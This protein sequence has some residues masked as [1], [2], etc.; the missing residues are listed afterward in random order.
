MK[1]HVEET[2]IYTSANNETKFGIEITGK[3]F[4]LLTGG[5]YK[6]K[7]AAIVREISANAYD[8]HVS[9]GKEDIPFKVILPNELHPYF[10]VEDYGVGLNDEEIRTIYTVLFRST[11]QDS[12]FDIGA[13]G[14]GSKT[15]I[16]YTHS[17]NI[18][19]RKDGIER[20]YT[21]YKGADGT[22][23]I[24]L[25]SEKVTSEG[26]GVKVSVPV[27]KEDF[28]RFESEAKFIL[29]FFKTRPEVKSSGF[30]FDFSTELMEFFYSEGVINTS[31]SQVTSELYANNEFYVVMGGVCY[32]V[33]YYTIR[34]TIVDYGQRNE[35]DT[36]LVR[37]YISN[38][39][40]GK[41][42][43]FV[44]V[45]IGSFELSE[46]S[47]SRESLSIGP[48]TRKKLGQFFYT[49]IETI[50]KRDQELIDEQP[51]F[52]KALGMLQKRGSINNGS[53]L[54][55][56]NY[57]GVNLSQ[58]YSM[59]VF[60]KHKAAKHYRVNYYSSR[61]TTDIPVLTDLIKTSPIRIVYTEK[62]DN[63]KSGLVKYTREM[64]SVNQ[65]VIVV[66][67]TTKAA[68]E[69]YLSYLGV[70][71]Y[72]LHSFTEY[73]EEQKAERAEARKQRTSSSRQQT[74]TANKYE[75]SEV[76]A[77]AYD[78]ISGYRIPIR[79]H[80]LA[81]ETVEYYRATD[82]DFCFE[83][84]LSKFQSYSSSK[85]CIEQLIKLAE[86][87][88]DK[89]SIIILLENSRNEGKLTRNE[90]PHISELNKKIADK[91]YEK[92]N[93]EQEVLIYIEPYYQNVELYDA[94]FKQSENF[95]ARF[96]ASIEANQIEL[97]EDRSTITTVY[98][99]RNAHDYE[100]KN[101]IYEILKAYGGYELNNL[102]DNKITIDDRVLKSFVAEIKETYPLIEHL[103]DTGYY[104]FVTPDVTHIIE[105]MDLIDNHKAQS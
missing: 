67:N 24:N 65:P 66:H 80:N 35:L 38:R 47:A 41:Y 55:M 71:D 91:L 16:T 23:S 100:Q 30:E 1:V 85:Y 37:N 88:T 93:E 14:L 29:S 48:E 90:I 12:N 96:L 2:P 95:R 27:P 36:E 9:A 6:N 104:N 98:G 31:T 5:I 62:G 92:Y 79:I 42:A 89:K 87:E 32:P 81:D 22:P 52:P 57:R 11:K 59:K 45:P 54:L 83:T 49:A 60:N 4:D 82:S 94:L 10:E 78:A 58:A 34:E 97:P 99:S 25:M 84:A 77:V 13:F 44:D 75:D 28:G 102:K 56:Y 53:F 63:R 8:S 19:A 43:L 50:I 101:G 46:I 73:Y 68:L 70:E 7:I 86:Y 39:I 3:A 33:E 76:Y 15:P 74:T 17:F 51:N 21:C 20:L 64:V 105:Y 103:L 18:R 72:E 26:N 61:N 40:A 69:R